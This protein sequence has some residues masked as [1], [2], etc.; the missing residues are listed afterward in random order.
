M[1]PCIWDLA[2]DFEGGYAVVSNNEHKYGIINRKGEIVIPQGKY[3]SIGE[4]NPYPRPYI[5]ITEANKGRGVATTDGKVI[6]PCRFGEIW[7]FHKKAIQVSAVRRDDVWGAW[8]YDGRE[9]VPCKYRYVT[10][11]DNCLIV[12]NEERDTYG[13]Y[14]YNGKMVVPYEYNL[15]EWAADNIY[16]IKKNGKYGYYAQ[17]REI[18]PCIYDDAKPFTSPSSFTT[19]TSLVKGLASS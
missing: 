2:L 14:D 9:L 3:E 7:F 18:I 1:I 10:I 19:A 12:C 16:L 11:Q 15:V 6:I 4:Y 5:G 8:S 13:A 17:G